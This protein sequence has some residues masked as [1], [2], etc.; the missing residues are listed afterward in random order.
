MTISAVMLTGYTGTAFAL[1]A[2]GASVSPGA[3]SGNVM[4]MPVNIPVNACGNTVDVIGALNP[5][6]GNAC[7]RELV[8]VDV[9]I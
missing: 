2:V 1:D 7:E 6:F 3:I 8:G 4:Q 5:A 9:D